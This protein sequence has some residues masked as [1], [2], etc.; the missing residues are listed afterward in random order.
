MM[1]PYLQSF[2]PPVPALDVQILH[3]ITSAQTTM[4]AK[5]DT[6]ADQTIIPVSLVDILDLEPQGLAIAQPVDSSA[7][8]YLTYLCDLIIAGRQ[9]IDFEAAAA[10]VSYILLGRDVLNQLLI[11]LDGPQLQFEIR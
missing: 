8:V 3:P 5:I 10:P 9:F 1:F 6:A 11:T 4:L 2:S 7:R